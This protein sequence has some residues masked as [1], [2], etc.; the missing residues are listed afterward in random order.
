MNIM[1][2]GNSMRTLRRQI[3]AATI[4][5][6]GLISSSS[7]TELERDGNGKG[8]GGAQAS[9]VKAMVDELVE[10]WEREDLDA[11][12]AIFS[13][14]AVVYDPGWP[15]GK[16]EGPEEIRNWTAGHF[17]SFDEIDLILS[18]RTVRSIGRVAWFQAEYALAVRTA[19]PDA[20]PTRGEGFLSILWVKQADGTYKSPLFHAIARPSSSGGETR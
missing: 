13:A 17:E 12:V 19:E 7:S 20:E 4:L 9:A 2:S 8:V 1:A 5:I 3:I 18:E 14:E 10:T 6:A 16:F 11:A 15:P